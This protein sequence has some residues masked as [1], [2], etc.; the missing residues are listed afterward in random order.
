[1]QSQPL[2][3]IGAPRSGTTFLCH[4]LNRDPRIEITN[5]CRVFIAFKNLIDTG[6]RRPDLVG[7]EFH[8]PFARFMRERVGELVERF[9]RETLGFTAPIWGDK[10]PPYADPSVLSGRRRSTPRL[11]QSGSCLRLI[12]SSL[13][14]AKFIHIHRNPR[15]VAHSLV[16][17]GWT[18]SV[19]DGLQVW[20]QYVEEVVAFMAE[21][22]AERHLT[23]PYRD[24]I[25]EPETTAARIGRF[26]RLP[27]CAA[28][29]AF[30][31]M[32]RQNPTPFSDPVTDV[33]QAFRRKTP[34]AGLN[35]Q[36]LAIAGRAAT[37]LGYAG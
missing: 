32:Q 12:A 2:F 33:E 20:R 11:P 3:V 24:L 15:E 14:T 19:E 22:D 1:M 8:D 27:D 29:A 6:A 21:I 31:L 28:I 23:I 34:P 9:Y 25:E 36:A 30:L 37:R 26:L 4:V 35:R 16:L 10:H 7:R 5:E 17:K 13:P 18:P